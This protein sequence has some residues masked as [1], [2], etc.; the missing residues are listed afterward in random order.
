VEEMK[1]RTIITT[2]AN[3]LLEPLHDQMPA[4]L[5]RKAEATWLDPASQDPARLLPLLKPCPTEEMEVYSVSLALN[6]PT[7]DGPEC[8]EPL[9]A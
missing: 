6:D 9:R 3:Q 1:T 2:E 7:H 8:L 4:I 5:I